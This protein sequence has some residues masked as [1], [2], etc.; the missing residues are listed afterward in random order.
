MSFVNAFLDVTM[1]QKGMLPLLLLAAGL[2]AAEGSRGRCDYGNIDR[3]GGRWVV[4]AKCTHLYLSQVN[5]GTAG[6]RQMGEALRNNTFVTEI[7]SSSC[8]I[9]GGAKFL[10]AML[11]ENTVLLR[12]NLGNNRIDDAGIAAIARGLAVNKGLKSLNLALNRVSGDGA[13]ALAEALKTNTVL[14]TLNLDSNKLGDAGASAMADGLAENKNLRSIVLGGNDIG[15]EGA[16]AIAAAVYTST[17]LRVRRRSQVPPL[18]INR[19]SHPHKPLYTLCSFMSE[20]RLHYPNQSLQ[21][22]FN[23]IKGEG[24]RL[25]AE[26]VMGKDNFTFMARHALHAAPRRCST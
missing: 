25:L 14:E 4:P 7:D 9:Q 8:S 11:A 1:R 3:R 18:V 26:A 19:P 2:V 24:C 12:L 6:A 20:A 16:A 21:V 10:E 13:L 23:R 15:N 5:F 17:T 22:R